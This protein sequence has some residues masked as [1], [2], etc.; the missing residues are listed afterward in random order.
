[1]CSSVIAEV[2][3][4][5]V[6]AAEAGATLDVPLGHKNDLWSFLHLGTITVSVLT[7]PARTRS[8]LLWPSPMEAGESARLQAATDRANECEV[9]GDAEK[10]VLLIGKVRRYVYACPSLV[11][12]STLVPAAVIAPETR[13]AASAYT[14]EVPRRVYETLRQKA[15]AALAAGY[16]VIIDAVSLKPEERRSFAA[17]AEAAADP[18]SGLWLAAPASRSS[19]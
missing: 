2:I 1:M 13:L 19:W 16:S 14:T 11:A 15:A 18:F 4:S 7:R 17:V 12:S 3:S 10:A 8:S 9:V 6:K 5:N